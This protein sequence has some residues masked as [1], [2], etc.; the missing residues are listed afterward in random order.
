MKIIALTN[1][2]LLRNEVRPVRKSKSNFLIP[3][4]IPRWD[5][6]KNYISHV[7]SKPTVSFLS[8]N[9]LNYLGTRNILTFIQ[10]RML[11]R[12]ILLEFQSVEAEIKVSNY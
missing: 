3:K 7:K 10:A 2:A 5:S 11:L 4:L 6:V 12:H 9:S 8:K 1:P